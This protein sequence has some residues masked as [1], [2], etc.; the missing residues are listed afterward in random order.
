MNQKKGGSK[1]KH[2]QNNTHKQANEPA[3]QAATKLEKLR[4]QMPKKAE[5]N[6]IKAANKNN[7]RTTKCVKWMKEMCV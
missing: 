4:R 6:G 3:S 7:T 2:A 1:K 5:K